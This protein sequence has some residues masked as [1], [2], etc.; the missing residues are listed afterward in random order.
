MIYSNN[1]YLKSGEFRSLN[2]PNHQYFCKQTPDK[3]L[4]FR[5]L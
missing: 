2:L 5:S 1:S 4:F 3:L